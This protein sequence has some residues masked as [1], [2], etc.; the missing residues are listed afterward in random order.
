VVGHTWY[1]SVA[2]VEVENDLPAM[3]AGL[4]RKYVCEK[5]AKMLDTWKSTE[6]NFK[7]RMLDRELSSTK[8]RMSV[9]QR[10]QEHKEE[11]KHSHPASP[12]R[13]C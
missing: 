2:N 12:L 6:L 10:C 13:E 9:C 8:M 4:K 5:G 1:R 3:K 7:K 11:H